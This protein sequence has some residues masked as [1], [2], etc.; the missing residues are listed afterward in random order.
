MSF[1]YCISVLADKTPYELWQLILV[2]SHIKRAVRNTGSRLPKMGDSFQFNK[3]KCSSIRR[4]KVEQS[5]FVCTFKSFRDLDIISSAYIRS[6]FWTPGKG[7]E[8]GPLTPAFSLSQSSPVLVPYNR[9]FE[10]SSAYEQSFKTT[11]RCKN[12]YSIIQHTWE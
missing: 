9:D 5:I 6:G 7:K 8:T 4:I 3:E 11:Q 10:A 12:T 2:L 1:R